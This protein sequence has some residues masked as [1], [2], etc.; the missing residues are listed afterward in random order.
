MYNS[1][2][3]SPS[4]RPNY[5]VS[6]WYNYEFRFYTYYEDPACIVDTDNDCYYP[7]CPADNDADY[8]HFTAVIW[9]VRIHTSLSLML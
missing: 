2:K 8:G 6:G 5:A 4:L 7:G 1:D 3:T 9:K